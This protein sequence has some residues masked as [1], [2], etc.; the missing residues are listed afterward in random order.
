M[1][2]KLLQH[3]LHAE[4]APLNQL[5]VVSAGVAA[6]YNDPASKNSV[7]TL[8]KVGLDLSCHHSQPVTQA[9]IDKSFAIFGMTESHLDSLKYYHSDLPQRLHLFREFLGE[10]EDSQIPDPYGQDMNAYQVCLDSMI[11]A[12]PSILEYLRREHR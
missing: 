10:D 7:I 1:A 5:Q 6:G 11:E 9:L 4:D 8:K 2:E 3:A 12:I